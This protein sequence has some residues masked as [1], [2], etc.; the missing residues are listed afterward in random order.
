MGRA[1]GVVHINFTEFGQR[2]GEFGVVRF[3]LR[4]KAQILE[5]RDVAVL[6]VLNDFLRNIANRVVTE[7]D[8]L[9]NQGV[10]MIANRSQRVFLDALTL[11]PAKV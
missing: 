3:F 2:L 7:D 9:T 11:R 10:Q 8:R 5:Q 6:H 1:E 4:L